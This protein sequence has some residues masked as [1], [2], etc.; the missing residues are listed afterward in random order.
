MRC[1]ININGTIIIRF[2]NF[3][4]SRLYPSP[5]PPPPQ[6]K[7]RGRKRKYSS[8]YHYKLVRPIRIRPILSGFV[9]GENIEQRVCIEFCDKLL[10]ETV[11]ETY[12]MSLLAY[13]D[14]TV[15]RARGF[16][17]FKSGREQLLKAMDRDPN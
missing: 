6:K 13:R 14:E 4:N 1:N 2:S 9:T 8:E 15:S 10:G 11:T 16:E 17:R 7:R 12:Q 3:S 5:H